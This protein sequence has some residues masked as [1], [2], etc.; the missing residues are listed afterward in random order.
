MEMDVVKGFGRASV[1]GC[2]CC[3][4]CGVEMVRE[5]LRLMEGTLTP[6]GMIDAAAGVPTTFPFGGVEGPV[7]AKDNEVRFDIT[8][9]DI[10]LVFGKIDVDGIVEA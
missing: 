1:W 3:C 5:L 6:L 9:T 8:E 7:T 2:C 4:C 10:R